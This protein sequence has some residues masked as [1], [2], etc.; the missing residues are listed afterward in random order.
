MALNRKEKDFLRKRSHNVKPIF[1]I[2]KNGFTEQMMSEIDDAIE[3]RE[4]IKIQ[5][6]KNTL[7]EASDVEE[8]I[9]GNTDIQVVQVIGNVLILY[10][11]SSY[12]NNRNISDQVRAL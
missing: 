10:K 8:Y 4:L 3:K 12:E 5:L 2:G 6:L 7:L 1:Q 9:E 11:S